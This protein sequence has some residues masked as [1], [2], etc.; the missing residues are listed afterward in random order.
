MYPATDPTSAE[1]MSAGAVRGTGREAEAPGGFLLLT[2]AENP[3][4]ALGPKG[5]LRGL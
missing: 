4:S 3:A 2:Q 5:P 1:V